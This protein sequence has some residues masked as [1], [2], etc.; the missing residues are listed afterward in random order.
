MRSIY[1]VVIYSDESHICPFLWLLLSITLWLAS[2]SRRV[3]LKTFTMFNSF[4]YILLCNIW[5]SVNT[6]KILWHV[7][8]RHALWSQQWA[9]VTCL[10]CKQDETKTFSARLEWRC[11]ERCV[12]K[13]C[14]M[15]ALHKALAPQPTE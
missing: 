2:I 6:E 7:C 4:Y 9:A 1:I 8:S 11:K 5:R 3:H 10:Q 13:Q 12:K 14:S 15:L